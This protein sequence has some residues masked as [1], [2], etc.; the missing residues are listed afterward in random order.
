MPPL[1]W[2]VPI[3]VVVALAA[4]GGRDPVEIA[5]FYDEICP[6][7]DDYVIAEDIAGRVVSLGRLNRRVRAEAHNAATATG[8]A[9]LA[10]YVDQHAVP[11]ISASMPLLFVGEE[12]TVGYEE[13]ED[14]VA[15][16]SEKGR[17]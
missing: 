14:R 15:E 1:R 8:Q 13:I 3:A 17:L 2:A 9:R 12:Y 11:D 7:C 5:F 6:S 10:E 16:L 4:C